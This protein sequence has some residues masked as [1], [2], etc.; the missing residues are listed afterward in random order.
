[1][2]EPAR[3][4]AKIALHPLNR[5]PMKP[6]LLLL[7]L[8]LLA[9]LIL[10]V[11]VIIKPAKS[12]HASSASSSS[13]ATDTGA[14]STSSVGEYTEPQKAST[15]P[16]DAQ[17]SSRQNIWNQLYSADLDQLI[18]RLK[19][20]G[21]SFREIRAITLPLAQK[22]F[23]AV[24]AE[25]MGKQDDRPYWRASASYYSAPEDP[26]QR[27]KLMELIQK[28]SKLYQ[29]YYSSPEAIA[30]DEQMQQYARRQFGDLPVEKL[31][32]LSKIQTDYQELQ[33]ELYMNA[34]KRPRSELNDDE[35]KQLKLLESERQRDILQTLSPE[36]YTEYLLRSSPTANNLRQQLDLFRPTEAEYK[37]LFALQRPID[38]QYSGFDEA[39]AKARSE[40]M[41]NLEPQI[42]AALGPERYADYK[43]AM[44]SG[45]DKVARLMVRLDLPLG[46]VSKINAVRD[47]ITQRA[48]SVR[49]DQQLSPAERDLRLSALA[50][51][52][53]N[54][55][56]NTLGGQRGLEAYS[57]IKGDWLRALQ[58]KP[59]TP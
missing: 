50:Q 8:T 9:N 24:R 25:V 10:A 54:R 6:S 48:K 42:Q 11:A 40:A 1:M 52:A 21:F 4:A 31:Q 51:E 12:S 15:V 22:R 49:N 53:Q 26:A 30:E 45:G 57:D 16:G 47:D 37:A 39:S 58:P 17:A 5:P 7:S 3:P 18:S 46:T 19:A 32:Q 2:V 59:A 14:H 55:L 13:H 27:A 29:K 28:E 23:E 41:K 38:E 34:Q 56:S 44:E 36:Q 33:M 20:A 43:Q 35:K